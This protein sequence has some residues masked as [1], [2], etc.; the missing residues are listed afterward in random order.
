MNPRY[1]GVSGTYEKQILGIGI[2]A[3]IMNIVQ[4]LSVIFLNHF[5]LPYGNVEIAAMG[6]AMK[7][8][9]I[10]N[11][12]LIGL[13]YG[14]Q[15]LFGYFFGAEDRENLKKLTYFNLRLSAGTAI[16]MSVVV[17]AAAEPLIR[18]F[19]D[20]AEIVQSGSMMLR[21]QVTTMTFAGITL[22]LTLIF[23]SAGRIGISFLLSLS[24]QGVIFLIILAIASRMFG[25]IGVL[26][27]QAAADVISVI[28]AGILFYHSIYRK[29]KNI[30]KTG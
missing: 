21:M 22:L 26:A 13:A 28:L 23:Q 19:M 18:F 7:T 15:P 29:W 20:D 16:V 5:L 27:S 1:F 3:A 6:I 17:F 30:R 4:S 11:L 10:V 12:V 8:V 14:G 24:R 2:P 25:Y 9:S